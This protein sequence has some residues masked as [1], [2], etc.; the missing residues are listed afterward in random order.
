M[1]CELNDQYQPE[2][3]GLMPFVSH[4]RDFRSRED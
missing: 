4:N 1:V 2:S 3:A